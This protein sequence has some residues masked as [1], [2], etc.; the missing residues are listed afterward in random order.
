ME[1]SSDEFLEGLWGT[2]RSIWVKWL[3]RNLSNKHCPEC[4]KLDKCWFLKTKAPP[5][6]HHPH[7]H[8]LLQPISH[9]VVLKNAVTKSDYSKFDPYL[10]DPENFYKHGKNKMFENW[11]YTINDS[12]WLQKEI[13]KQGL[14]KYVQG[15]YKLGVLNKYGQRISIRIEIPRRGTKESVS[16]I[17]G[18]T[19]LPNGQIKLNTPYG[20]E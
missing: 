14:E 19:V 9:D 18:W 5:W 16:F 10:F 1:L 20:G 8:C 11:G 6:P 12:K 7:C 2:P 13:E 3:H 4:L 15:D 17:T